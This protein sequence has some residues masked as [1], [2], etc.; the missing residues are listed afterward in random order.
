MMA[1]KSKAG[2]PVGVSTEAVQKFVGLA[3]AKDDTRPALTKVYAVDQYVFAA[4]GSSLHA[5]RFADTEARRAVLPDTDNPSFWNGR[6]LLGVKANLSVR[7]HRKELARLI[8]L[9]GGMV[10]KDQAIDLVWSAGARALVV[11]GAGYEGDSAGWLPAP[12]PGREYAQDTQLAFMPSILRASVRAIPADDVLISF[13][14]DRA[15]L[16]G[17]SGGADWFALVMQASAGVGRDSDYK[18]TRA[19]ARSLASE[20]LQE[21]GGLSGY[22]DHHIYGCDMPKA[23][24]VHK[25]A[26]P[27]WSLSPGPAYPPPPRRLDVDYRARI[28]LVG[29]LIGRGVHRPNGILRNSDKERAARYERWAIRYMRNGGMLQ[30]SMRSL[31]DDGERLG[32][33]WLVMHRSA[34]YAAYA[35][36]RI[37]L[38]AMLIEVLGDRCQQALEMSYHGIAGAQFEVERLRARMAR[39]NK[40][41]LAL[42]NALPY[43]YRPEVREAERLGTVR[44]EHYES[45]DDARAWVE[46]MIA[47]RDRASYAPYAAHPA[48]VGDSALGRVDWRARFFALGMLRARL[49]ESAD[50]AQR[51]YNEARGNPEA[52]NSAARRVRSLNARQSRAVAYFERITGRADIHPIKRGLINA[53]DLGLDCFYHPS[54]IPAEYRP[55]PAVRRTRPGRDVRAVRRLAI[56]ARKHPAVSRNMYG[57]LC[58]SDRDDAY[59]IVRGIVRS[60]A[61]LALVGTLRAIAARAAGQL[62]INAPEAGAPVVFALVGAG[63]AGNASAPALVGRRIV[64]KH[65]AGRLID[66]RLARTRVRAAADDKPIDVSPVAEPINAPTF[67]D[68]INGLTFDDLARM[69]GEKIARVTLSRVHD[70][71][72]QIGREMRAAERIILSEIEAARAVPSVPIVETAPALVGPADIDYLPIVA[73]QGEDVS[74]EPINAPTFGPDWSV[75]G[76]FWDTPPAPGL[77]DTQPMP[78]IEVDPDPDDHPPA[79]EGGG[80]DSSA[81]VAGDSSQAAPA[82]A[83]VGPAGS[84]G[85]SAGIGAPTENAFR[86]ANSSEGVGGPAGDKPTDV[87]PEPIKPDTL[88]DLVRTAIEV[89]LTIRAFDLAQDKAVRKGDKATAASCAE[90]VRREERTYAV[91]LAELSDDLADGVRD[92]VTL[93]NEVQDRARACNAW[94]DHIVAGLRGIIEAPDYAGDYRMFAQEVRA[95]HDAAERADGAR[96]AL[97][98]L[99]VRDDEAI[100]WRPLFALEVMAC[101]LRNVRREINKALGLRLRADRA[102]RWASA[103]TH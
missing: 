76:G 7:V 59:C 15:L 56:Y 20:C 19:H 98:G 60:G 73:D 84:G 34:D 101:T 57:R 13:S 42:S 6:D 58:C 4:N 93:S 79:P 35:L 23:R 96:A 22:H 97:V 95:L 77:E 68:L 30:P 36:P 85:S 5:V 67:D 53:F 74:A 92:F 26:Y 78:A 100:L 37:K 12:N 11:V 21:T 38:A 2:A 54:D 25:F 72:V 31:L 17:E 86:N 14:D 27:A 66:Q 62:A 102:E 3:T 75:W 94:G 43:Q 63:N 29:M 32:R 64:W 70:R 81:Q 90:T 82:L 87:S 28:K 99:G 45:A 40:R 18:D 55:A 8:D 44:G 41:E 16:W 33:D 46:R 1:R 48:P 80:A 103:E 61:A 52:R 50:I 9:A 39:L 88:A 91:L 51:D 24:P 69:M 10:G 71:M 49:R 83:L 89:G 65:R 47:R